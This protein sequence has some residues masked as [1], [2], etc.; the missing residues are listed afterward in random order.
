MAITCQTVQ[1]YLHTHIPLAKAMA[2]SVESLQ[3]GVILTA[4]LEPNLNHRG[5]AFG[6]SIST[7]AILS[8]WAFVHVRLQEQAIPHRLV[9]RRNSVE[10]LKPID[11]VLSVHC[12]AP[13][14]NKWGQFINTLMRKGKGRINLEANILCGQILAGLF[15]G[16]Y[17]ALKP[18]IHS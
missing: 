15:K 9:I 17:V 10:Y 6:G 5:T 2:V 1:D 3:G 16:E 11:G 4:P 8:A 7:L 13:P 12:Q 18:N 14:Q